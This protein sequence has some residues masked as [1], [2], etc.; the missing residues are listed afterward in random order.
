[1]SLN[2]IK[3]ESHFAGKGQNATCEI[4]IPLEHTRLL[5]EPVDGHVPENGGT[6]HSQF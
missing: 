1:M 6:C 3:K 5:T 4:V 2:E